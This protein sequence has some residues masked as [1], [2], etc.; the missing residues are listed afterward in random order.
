MLSW[1]PSYTRIRT[2]ERFDSLGQAYTA[3]L[4]EER[5]LSAEYFERYV[6]GHGVGILTPF[7]GVLQAPGPLAGHADLPRDGDAARLAD[8]LVECAPESDPI[9]VAVSGGMDSWVLATLL[10]SRGFAVR[11]WYLES[12]VPG[13]CEVKR[14]RYLSRGLGIPCQCVRVT[15]SEF[16]NALPD[17]VEAVESPIYNLHPVSKWLLAQALKNEG[18]SQLVT[19]DGA[20]QVMR[21]ETDCDLLPLTLSCFRASDVDLITPFLSEKVVRMCH[22]PDPEK[23]IVRALAE[24]LGVPNLKKHATLF[25][26]IPL[27][28]DRHL[29][30]E[31]RP[32]GSGASTDLLTYT[33][34]LLLE[35]LEDPR[36]CAAS[37]V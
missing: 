15:E 28:S 35:A 7:R 25:P 1:R 34:S 31:P 19:G 26:A 21:Q 6:K 18:V 17:F 23:R 14:V 37:R 2:G 33:T 16:V 13:Y 10:R 36:R 29:R 4:P 20:D 9:D 22:R 30:S 8:A 12:G 3:C 11:A 27:P 24:Q 5:V 32:R